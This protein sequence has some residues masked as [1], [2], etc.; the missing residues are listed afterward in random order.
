MNQ[1]ELTDKVVEHIKKEDNFARWLGVEVIS[2][3]PGYAKIKMTI[4]KDMINSFGS[5]HGGVT[6]AFAQTALAFASNNYGNIE[7]ALETSMAFTSPIFEGDEI[8]A[9]TNEESR[10]NKV[11]VYTIDVKKTDG[12]K[13]GVFRGSVYR[14][15]R[16][17]FPEII[18]DE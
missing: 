6:F 10:K 16:K 12:T 1:N 15:K 11:S 8:I 14:T 7:V 18:L 5:C 3:K 2:S 17:Y 13:V 9:E 4:R